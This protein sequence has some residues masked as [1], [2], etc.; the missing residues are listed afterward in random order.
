MQRYLS[1]GYFA[2][3]LGGCLLALGSALALTQASVPFS[4]QVVTSGFVVSSAIRLLGGAAVI[5]GLTAIYV[6]EASAA[7]RLGLTAYALVVLNLVLQTGTMWADLFVTGALAA[8]APQVLDGFASDP[9]LDAGF[10]GAWLMNASFVLL[11]IATLRARVFPRL[12]GW[13]LVLMGA[14]TLVPLPVD[15]PAYEIGIGAACV[16]AGFSARRVADAPTVAREG[17]SALAMG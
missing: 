4:E 2:T 3:I 5:I 10:L 8:H 12:C 6:R 14:I 15:G 7:G 1:F 17:A 11:G 16:L 13:M 9:R